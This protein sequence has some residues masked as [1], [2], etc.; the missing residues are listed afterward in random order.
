MSVMDETNQ[1]PPAD[2]LAAGPGPRTSNTHRWLVAAVWVAIA[3]AL[4]LAYSHNFVHMWGRWFPRWHRTHQEL[5]DRIFEGESYYTHGPLIPLISAIL[6]IMV[7]RHSKIPVRPSPRWGLAVLSL[8]LLVHLA[9]CL[10]R[11]HFVSGF[12]IIGVIVG[13]VLTFWGW[14][15]LRRLW[16]PIALL[17]FMVPLPE[18]SIAQANF[19]LKIL[20]S[21][22]GVKLANMLGIIVNRQGNR[23]FIPGPNIL[24][25][26]TDTKTLVVA[27]V[28]NGLRTL[29]SLLAT[30]A[31]YAYVCRVRGLW[32]IVLFLL[33]IPIA[34]I[35][36]ATRIVSLIF[37]ADVW[38]VKAATGWWHDFS[39][40]LIFVMALL[41]LYG[42]ELLILW[43]YKLVGK[44]IKIG[45]LL[46]TSRR[47][48]DDI[49]QW[50]RLVGAVHTRSGYA[51]VGMLAVATFG[52]LWLS[53]VVRPNVLAI[54][55]QARKA[56]SADLIVEGVRWH[57]IE[58]EM[59]EK[60]LDILETQTY[61]FR[62][63][64]RQDSGSGASGRAV[65]R[66]VDFCVIFSEDNRKG[67]HPPDLCLEGMGT[68]IQEKRDVQVAIPEVAGI[69]SLPCRELI[70]QAGE[71]RTYYLYTYMCG[72]AFTRSFWRQQAIIFMN[73]LLKRNTLGALIR[74]TVRL[75]RGDEDEARAT[76][77]AFLAAALP[78]LHQG[79]QDWRSEK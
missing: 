65:S 67:V 19:R 52:A 33:T 30:G 74:V 63:Y 49:A 39:G 73:G 21:T 2:L 41:L 4:V 25:D 38:D 9:S 26:P 72:D 22:S 36:N 76:A 64:L 35:A 54:R 13:L 16:F 11:V 61:V 69:T 28:C 6:V 23:V 68:E 53:Q 44:P 24:T 71:R 66:A 55:A 34:I 79:L 3:A 40:L 10:A 57:G 32:R 51:V 60:V 56:L 46:G 27:N 50:G 59:N 29:I 78:D 77:R 20:A 58:R 14:T 1:S 42:I 43:G 47:D 31:L 75:G 5:Y 37:V 15:A 8:S 12:T 17:A 45:A 62:T 70:V 18:V 7:V 48:P